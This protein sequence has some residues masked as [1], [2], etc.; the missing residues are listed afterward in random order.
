MQNIEYKKFLNNPNFSKLIVTNKINIT[1][2]DSHNYE[3]LEIKDCDNL[4]SLIDAKKNFDIIILNEILTSIQNIA[5]ILKIVNN[6]SNNKTRVIVHNKTFFY[7]T[8]RKTLNLLVKKKYTFN[9]LNSN[10]LNTYFENFGYSLIRKVKKKFIPY[11]NFV[12]RFINIILSFIPFLPV[13]ALEEFTFFKR[14]VVQNPDLK[15]YGASICLTVKDEKENIENIVKKIPQISTQQ[16]IIF[17]EGGST[18][19][20]YEEVERIISIYPDKNIKVMKQKGFGQKGAIKTGFD[21]SLY[22]AII[23]FE[24][25]DTCDPNDMFYF[26]NSIALGRADFLQ[27]TR[28][29]YPLEHEQMP[30]INKIGNFF[31]ALWFTWILGQ[32][33]TDVL[34]PIKAINKESYLKASSDWETFGEDDPFGDFELMFI[35]ARNS[36]KFSEI[37]ISYFPRKYG[38]TKTNVLKHGARLFKLMLKLHID[39][40]A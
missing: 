16:E 19:G 21:N 14:E 22:K 10:E 13:M 7:H 3:N 26:Y 35:M 6:L 34:S 15:N 40:K 31:F 4:Q 1:E 17:I 33:V 28:L 38:E 5:K 11:D 18:D 25:D 20:T 36:F 29:A 27:G 32:R 23:L 12:F 8:A 39:F 24:G 9:W 2:F 37:P 30:L